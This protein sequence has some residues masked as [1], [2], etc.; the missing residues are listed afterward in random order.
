MTEILDLDDPIHNQGRLEEIARLRVHE[1]EV[2]ELLNEYT[3]K[4]AWEFNLP[5][6]LVSV[7][8]D[9]V[10][11]FVASYGLGG[12]IKEVQ[13]SPVEWSFCANSVKTKEPFI[14]EDADK[15]LLVKNNPLVTEDNIKCYAGVPLIT[16][17]GYIIGNFCVIGDT[18][19]D[20]SEADVNRLRE[21][22]VQVMH[23]LEARV[24]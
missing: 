2:D 17:N 24:A 10:Q 9:D 23:H 22:A 5:T 19:R 4:A 11:K 1:E 15:D 21:Y 7:V 3:S 13:G 14:V 16:V 20:F 6:C 8:L 18:S 12:W